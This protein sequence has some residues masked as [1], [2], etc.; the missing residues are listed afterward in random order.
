MAGVAS[1]SVDR[2]ISSDV[3]EHIPDIYTAVA[4]M[5][6][7]LR[8]GGLLVVNTPNAAYVKRRFQLPVGRFPSTSQSNEGLGSDVLFDGGHL[9]YFTYRSLQLLLERGG[10]R[11]TGRQSYGRFGRLP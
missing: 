6:R 5:R 8:P 1:S 11:V 3:V 4:E 7:V 2:I 9:H 10:F